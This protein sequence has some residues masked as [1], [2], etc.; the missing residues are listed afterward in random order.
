MTLSSQWMEEERVGVFYLQKIQQ[1]AKSIILEPRLTKT[2]CHPSEVH[3]S[4]RHLGLPTQNAL[5]YFLLSIRDV[6]FYN[7]S[8]LLFDLRSEASASRSGVQL[9][10]M[11]FKPTNICKDFKE[12]IFEN[13]TVSVF[14]VSKFVCYVFRV[15]TCFN[16]CHASLRLRV[17]DVY[18]VNQ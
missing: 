1:L 6:L 8:Q 2:I 13:Y 10:N 4:V 18:T 9:P 11:N 15:C 16:Q 12:Y 3:I 17:Y 7:K 5:P 14:V